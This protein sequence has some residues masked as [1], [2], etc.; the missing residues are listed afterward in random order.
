MFCKKG[1]LKDFVNFIGK[2]LCWTLF[3]IKLQAW[4]LFRRTSA[5]ECFWTALAPL[6]VTNPF[7]FIFS[8]FFLI[9]T[10]TTVNISD[11]CF[12]FKSKGFKKFKSGISFSLKSISSLLISFYMFFL[13][14]SVLFHFVLSLLIKRT[15]WKAISSYNLLCNMKFYFILIWIRYFCDF[16]K[17]SCRLNH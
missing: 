8:T 17:N 7:Y 9:I 10:A 12:W 5:N 3:L 6:V 15:L 4:H 1:V 13:P 2:Q 16:F 11:V 14:F